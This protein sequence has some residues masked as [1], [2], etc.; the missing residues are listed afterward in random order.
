MKVKELI[1]KLQKFDKNLEVKVNHN[2]Q[3]SCDCQEY[4]YCSNEDHILQ[5]NEPVLVKDLSI[6]DQLFVKKKTVAREPKPS[7][8]MI[9][10]NS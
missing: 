10:V 6:Y 8:V 4:C 2:Y 3:P 9:N 5:I 7:V 1:E